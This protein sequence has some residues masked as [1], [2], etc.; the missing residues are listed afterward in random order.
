MD[1][2][3]SI[4]T[5]TLWVL[6]AITVLVFI[7]ELGHFL[8]AK[9]FGMRVERFS[10]GFPPTILGRTYGD[11][12][13]VLG[14]TPLGGY[15][16]ISGMIDESLDTDHVEEEPD[17]WEFRAK[18]VWQRIVVISA[19]VTFNVILAVLIFGGIR[20]AEGDTY[21]P[22][23]NVEQVYVETGSVAH[24]VGL[25][26]GDRILRVNGEPFERFEQ[27]TPS[28]VVA[29]DSLTITVRRDGET[30][31]LVGPS[32]I[33]TRLSRARNSGEVASTGYFPGLG[34]LPPLIGS[35]QKGSPADSI[36]LRPGDRI[37]AVGQDTVRFWQEMS[38][39]IQKTKGSPVAPA[40][41]VRQTEKG[42]VFRATAAPMY[43]EDSDR[44][45]LG[46]RGPG[47][48]P[49]TQKMLYAELGLKEVS[50]GPG[51]ALVSGMQSV[52]QNTR[53]IVVTL[54]RVI[55]GR[56]DLRESL[57]GPVMIAKVTSE[58]A[59]RGPVVF[60]RLVAVLSV[61]LAIMNILPIPALDGGQLLFLLYEAVTRR[62][63]S[64]RVRLVAQQIGMILLLGFM[65][66]LIF[67]D[68]LR[69]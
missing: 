67:N 30:R 58:A 34:F 29:A 21:I 8:T 51:E 3:L 48:T 10:V 69:L 35:V 15:V 25:R 9:Y 26:T 28:S 14:A 31:R 7:H 49:T 53:N 13:Y 52:W 2:L 37:L 16:K 39:L 38:T 65:A 18:P 17:P 42:P 40:T 47:S 11:T 59:E 27:I 32:N 33:I 6:L 66:F 23:Q 45:V 64:V 44:Y 41:L 43:L 5:S 12:E 19:G 50:F 55:T 36:G 46:V 4:V 22:A 1:L 20:W 60:W 63:P 57:G 62:R 68:I 54:K 56:D 61:T 24:D